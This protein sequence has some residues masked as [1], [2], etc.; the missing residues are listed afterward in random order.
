MST[1][2]A[3]QPSTNG[4]FLLGGKLNE[5]LV[6]ISWKLMAG[7]LVPGLIVMQTTTLAFP[8][9]QIFKHKQQVLEVQQ[10]LAD[11]ETKKLNASSTSSGS[12]VTRSTISKRRRM[13]SMESLDECLASNYDGLQIYA[14]CQELNGENII[15][16]VK[17]LTFKK[18][19]LATISRSG[20][21]TRARYAMFCQA[22]SIYVQLIHSDTAKYPINIESN[23]YNKLESMFGGAALEVASR[24][25][26][27]ISTTPI[28]VAT[29]WDEP[30]GDSTGGGEEGFPMNSVPLRPT[31]AKGSA[32]HIL[33]L[34]EPTYTDNRLASIKVPDQFDETV[35]DAAFKSIRYMVWSET[36]QRYQECKRTSTPSLL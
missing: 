23:I 16:L 24:P 22:L 29:P 1:L 35:F 9:L 34:A 20:D 25:R 10:A 5:C 17:V 27:S 36:W 8:I 21:E 28:S 13:Y 30:E 31:S 18:Q 12:L 33:P 2:T 14:S 11:F 19:W 6:R 7:R 15:F 3:L 4:L 26:N 32:E